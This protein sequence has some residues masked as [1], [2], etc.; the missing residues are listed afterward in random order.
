MIPT[1][2]TI[3]YTNYT[4]YIESLTA[5][6]TYDNRGVE[7]IFD[8]STD[9]TTG[10]W[11]SNAPTGTID[12]VFKNNVKISSFTITNRYAV[13]SNILKDFNLQGSNDNSSWNTIGTYTH[14]SAANGYCQE[15]NCN[16]AYPESGYKYYRL[17]ITSAHSL[18]ATIGEMV[19]TIE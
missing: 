3:D 17:N 14:N 8:G 11:H 12:F 6:S 1:S 16:Y 4:L 9:S 2:N 7:N 13:D 18:Y 19:I 10:E 15:Y 5:S